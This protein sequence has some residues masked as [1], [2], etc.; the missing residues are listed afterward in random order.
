VEAQTSGLAFGS[1]RLLRTLAR[2]G[3]AEVMLAEE[4]GLEGFRR[5][6]VIKRVLPHLADDPEFVAMFL[7]EARLAALLTHPG[8]VHIYEFGSH[9]GSFF[10]AMEYVE[11]ASLSQIIRRLGDRR[12]PVEHAMKITA[13]VCEALQYTH[14]LRDELGKP[15][16]LVHRDVSPQNVLLSVHGT[17]KL[18]DFGIAKATER[19]SN[20]RSGTIKGKFPYM[21]PE[22][23]MGAAT[24]ARSDVFSIGV[25]L[26]EMMTGRKLYGGDEPGQI[27][28]RIL[29]E[30]VP[31]LSDHVPGC[32]TELD[33][34]LARALAKQPE[35]RTPTAGQLQMELER[36]MA[37]A[38]LFSNAPTLAAYLAETGVVAPNEMRL[39]DPTPPRQATTSTAPLPGVGALESDEAVVV[40]VK[41]STT[42]TG[43]PL[44]EAGPAATPPPDSST[45]RSPQPIEAVT[46]TTRTPTSE[47]LVLPASRWR[48]LWWLA[49]ACA[50]A[51]GAFM[52]ISPR[53]PSTPP[54]SEAAASRSSVQRPAVAVPEAPQPPAPREPSPEAAAEPASREPPPAVVAAHPEA[55]PAPATE[56]G[57]PHR[58]TP[59]GAQARPGAPRAVATGL[60]SLD[61]T[62]WSRVYFHARLLG[63]TPLAEVRLP[64]GRQVLVCVDGQGQR[65]SVTV[66]VVPG[67][68]TRRRVQF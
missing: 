10:L 30:P 33:D 3:M 66:V 15:L 36:A 19:S 51:V 64:A 13:G 58:A 47:V 43:I 18:A 12:L 21:A 68:V 42:L 52:A 50:L 38:G 37:R 65:H 35:E 22:R 49:A 6:V 39:V 31:R 55:P 5:R 8:I 20:T 44:A 23:L 11:G 48:R 63:E 2:G 34:I 9:E 4:R 67:E 28:T 7:E 29:T 32:P 46:V 59:D 53:R 40:E 62:P 17:V 57:V 1:Y 41:F 27:V 26:F 61:T 54:S 60:V 16:G 24:D 45:P 56:G 25:V 14:A